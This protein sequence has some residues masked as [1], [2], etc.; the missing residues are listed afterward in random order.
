MS[1]PTTPLMEHNACHTLAAHYDSVAGL[2]LRQP[3][4]RDSRR[5]ERMTV[6]AVGLYLDYSKNRV[7]DETLKLLLEL[8]EKSG[9]RGLSTR[10]FE[11]RR[12]ISRRPAPFC[13]WPYADREELVDGENAVS[14]M[15]AVLDNLAESCFRRWA[16]TSAAT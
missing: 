6:E 12:S 2:S 7:T 11:A 5:G 15:H 9:L 14:E 3:F 4:T 1:R 8:A 16:T 10:C 13:T